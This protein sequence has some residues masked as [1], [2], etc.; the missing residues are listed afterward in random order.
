MIFGFDYFNK[1]TVYHPV[2]RTL[3]LTKSIIGLVV[4]EIALQLAYI[5]L[6]LQ[7]IPQQADW[8]WVVALL[9]LAAGGLVVPSIF[10]KQNFD[11]YRQTL[12]DHG[13][14]LIPIFIINFVT[15]AM[16]TLTL[17]VTALTI[18]LLFVL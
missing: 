10:I 5:A 6:I 9:V 16:M 14:K 8:W 11:L 1:G 2:R 17:L 4:T 15:L 18:I 12:K 13:V 3:G 7:V